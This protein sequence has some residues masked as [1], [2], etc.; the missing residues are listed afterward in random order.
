MNPL[1]KKKISIA[2]L[3][4]AIVCGSLGLFIAF[5]SE[6]APYLFFTNLG[7][8]L[9]LS[10]ALIVLVA[11]CLALSKKKDLPRWAFVL[12]YVGTATETLIFLIVCLY[13]VWVSGPALLYKGSFI[14]LH[15][16]CP[17]LAIG[18]HYFFIGKADFKNQDGLYAFLPPLLYAC[19]L[20]PLCITKTV[21]PPYPFLDFS[22]N[23]WWLSL[24][25][26]IAS[27]VIMWLICYALIAYVRK[28]QA[29]VEKS[30]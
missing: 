3:I 16:I 8:C 25:F 27:L 10:V 20:I 21:E 15:V 26:S 24:L 18:N 5:S 11:Q 28:T 9:Y 19:V 1:T 4:T 14:F 2:I 29:I 12:H 30:R 13:L 23:P 7:N 22:A 17:L 6:G